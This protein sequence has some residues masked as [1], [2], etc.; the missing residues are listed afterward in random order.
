MARSFGAFPGVQRCPL[1]TSEYPRR[2]ELE[3]M[4]CDEGFTKK[5]VF[6]VDMDECIILCNDA[7][8]YCIMLYDII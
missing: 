2:G 1:S 6:C 7:L 4:S 5:G 8:L 3:K